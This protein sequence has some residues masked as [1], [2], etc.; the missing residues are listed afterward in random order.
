MNPIF[1]QGK[2]HGIGYGYGTFLKQFINICNEHLKTRRA[3]SFAFILYDFHDENIKTI[4][5]EQGVFTQLDRLS[6]KDL[7][8]F[9]ID[10]GK[11]KLIKEFNKIFLGAFEIEDKFQ[12]PLVLFFNISNNE[13]EDIEVVELHQENLIFAFKELYDILSNYIERAKNSQVGKIENKTNK[14]YTTLS[15]IKKVAVEKI[16]ELIMMQG[17]DKLP[18]I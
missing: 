14:L 11:K 18:G 7:T 4:L 8:V 3:K 2:G 9:Y 10:S 16:I 12:K 15:T 13:V 17:F 1:E 6:G 5:K